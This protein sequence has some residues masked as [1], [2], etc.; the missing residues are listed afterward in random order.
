MITI[1]DYC[2]GDGRTFIIAEIGINHNGDIELAKQMIA[3]AKEAG[4]DAVKFQKRTVDIVYTPEELAKPRENPFGSTNGDLKRGLEFGAD[5][6]AQI[7]AYCKEEGIL[8]FASAWDEASLDFLEE[9]SVPCH[10]VAAAS[11]TDAG[12]LKKIRTTGKPVILSTG[13]SSNEEIEGAVSLL[14]RDKLILL[15]CTSLYPPNPN[16]INLR[17]MRTLRELY[18]VPVGYSGHEQD[19]L[20]STA[21]V[22]MGACVVER[23]FTLSR[24]MWGS[25]QKASIEP[26]EMQEL[27]SNIRVIEEALGSS[28]L[29]CLPDEIPNK[30]KLRRVDTLEI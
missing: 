19:T 14:N 23:H 17:A 21:A 26:V 6:Y 9:F 8:W 1:G 20:I 28:A 3:A 24:E 15:Q 4:C 27:V 5:E 2:I 11:L 18:G 22:A 7:D 10:K 25:D 16:Q 13:M 12:L 30:E 29:C